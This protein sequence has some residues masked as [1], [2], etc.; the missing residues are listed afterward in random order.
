MLSQQQFRFTIVIFCRMV[1][2]SVNGHPIVE[3]GLEFVLLD[4]RGG[5]VEACIPQVL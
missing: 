1:R 5:H 4:W 2:Q 3:V